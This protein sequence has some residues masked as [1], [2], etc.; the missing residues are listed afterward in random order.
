MNRRL[1][2]WTR[3]IGAS[4]VAA[5]SSC[6][7]PDAPATDADITTSPDGAEPDEPTA[8]RLFEAELALAVPDDNPFD[9]ERIDVV[10]TFEAPSGE[11]FEIPAFV[12][13]DYTRALV[14]GRERLEPTGPRHWRVR[15]RP[16]FGSAAGAWTWH[17]RATTPEGEEQSERMRFTPE[18]APDAHGVLRVSERDRRYLVFE[19]GSPYF[20]IGENMAWYDARGTHAYDDW[21]AELAEHGG[22]YIRVWMPSWAFGLEWVERDPAGTLAASSLGDYG[23]RLD[24]AWQLDHV[25]ALAEARGVRVMLTI[26]N[27]GPF[28]F[29]HASQWDDN[30]YNVENG[31][32]LA[33]PADVFSDPTARALHRRLLRY[34]VARWGHSES[35][36]AWEL[37]N[38]FDLVIDPEAPEVLLWTEEM[39]AELARLDPYDHLVT[40]SLGGIDV[41]VALVR[42]EVAGL[43][44]RMAFWASPAIDLTQLHFYG[45]GRTQLDFSRDVDTLVGYLRAFGKPA[46]VAEAGVNALGAAETL[47]D[48]PEGVAFHDILWA[49]L[50]AETFGSGMSWWWDGLNHPEGYVSHF[51]PLATLT[52][53]VR[54]DAERF[55]RAPAEAASRAGLTDLAA[56]ALLGERTTLAWIKNSRHQWFSVDATRLDDVVVT[57][58]AVPP[59]RWRVSWI[60]PYAARAPQ[61]SEV[62]VGDGGLVIDVPAFSRDVALRLDAIE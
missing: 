8:W 38:E 21:I 12:H 24:R 20:A 27:H 42:G 36:L 62:E 37:W 59:G 19:D 3:C 18:P 17:W 26:L 9:P 29:V 46:L 45:I 60:D 25:L 54:F 22:N 53:G 31:G 1:L 28:S 32:P 57:I 11:R 47:A 5:F 55:A 14:D 52:H 23:A 44:E 16:P 2:R 15:F 40:T 48:D 61:V 41:I 13:Q 51:A 56:F 6:G 49:G 7:D 50:F 33:D 30:P 39:A 4:L 35:I 10:A 58:A 43:V 34:I